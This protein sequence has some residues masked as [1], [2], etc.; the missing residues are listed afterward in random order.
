LPDT[1]AEAIPDPVPPVSEAAEEL[2]EEDLPGVLGFG[3]DVE[4]TVRRDG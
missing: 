1:D 3:L 2:P 4:G